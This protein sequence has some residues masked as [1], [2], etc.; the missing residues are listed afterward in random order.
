MNVTFRYHYYFVIK[1]SCWWSHFF[2]ELPFVLG[3]RLDVV[4]PVRWEISFVRKKFYDDVPWQV[5]VGNHDR[6]FP[7]IVHSVRTEGWYGY[8]L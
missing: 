3:S 4:A 8:N 5:S 2:K 1:I 6:L 7:G